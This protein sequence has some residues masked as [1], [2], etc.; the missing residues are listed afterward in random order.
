M[1][2]GTGGEGRPAIVWFR[3]DL[4]LADH[5][6]L[7]AALAG[8]GP[9]IPLYIL[10]ES[11]TQRPPGGAARW[12]LDRSLAALAADIA[13]RG[14]RLVLRRG[15]AAE[16][17]PQVAAASGAAA[18]HWNRRY[19]RPGRDIDAALKARLGAAGVAVESHQAGLLVEPWTIAPKSGSF[20]RVFTPFWKAASARLGELAGLGRAPSRLRAWNGPLQSDDRDGWGLHPRAPD[21][22]AGLAAAW[23]PGETA[24]RARLAAFLDGP[25]AGY[26][27]AR[28]FPAAGA[29]SRLAPHIRFGEIAVARVVAAVRDAAETGRLPHPD[30]D[31]FLAEIGWREFSWHLFFHFPELATRNFQPAFDAFPWREDETALA[32]WRRGRT[33]YPFVDAGMREL[34][35]TG[36][37]HN[38][39]RMVA[40]SFLTKHLLI[41][42]RVGEAWFW[43]TLV[44]ADVASNPANWQW[45]AGSGADAAPYFRIFNPAL[46]GGKFDPDGRYVRRWVPETAALSGAFARRAAAS[47]P[48]PIVE[49]AAARRRALAAFAAI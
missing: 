9:V 20:F 33:G 23:T 49:H 35:Q 4:R 42:W 39:A 30:A 37:M 48:P 21:W 41:D 17:L 5:P 27:E 6:A 22:S 1:T 11:A 24:A 12:W 46:Q 40:A 32:A 34:W 14:N 38:R 26:A 8:G 15:A 13:D 3:D 18:V 36:S 43:D 7:A 2:D 45:V 10:E 44:D 25:A 16:V 29:V 47:Y 19:D 31:K 28:D